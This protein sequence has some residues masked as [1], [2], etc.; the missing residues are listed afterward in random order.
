MAKV[1]LSR[2]QKFILSFLYQGYSDASS[3]YN[4]E[5]C[6][7]KA[8]EIFEEMERSDIYGRFGTSRNSLQPSFSRT[9][10]N[11]E[12]KGL[13]DAGRTK[14]TMRINATRSHRGVAGRVVLTQKGI[15]G[16]KTILLQDIKLTKQEVSNIKDFSKKAGVLMENRRKEDA[17][18]EK[19]LGLFGAVIAR[20]A[21]DRNPHLT[22]ESVIEEIEN[23]P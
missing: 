4:K 18:L 11:M 10:T 23:L 16:A 2:Q 6:G 7:Y 3:S 12:D 14:L 19:R 21:M 20:R 22:V 8:K 15:E 1:R 17:Y 5:P 9:L 13:I